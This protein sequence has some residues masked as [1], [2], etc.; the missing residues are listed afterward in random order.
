MV[1]TNNDLHVIRHRLGTRFPNLSMDI[2]DQ[3]P[4]MN[5][6][7]CAT[8]PSG[9]T[10]IVRALP[11]GRIWLVSADEGFSLDDV[12]PD[13][14]QNCLHDEDNHIEP[15]PDTVTTI[16]QVVEWVAGI[17]ERAAKSA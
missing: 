7:R 8:K 17:V 15:L 12:I 16:D 3:Y 6:I 13:K 4:V 11:I 14:W 9:T 2:H 10:L 5:G 1:F